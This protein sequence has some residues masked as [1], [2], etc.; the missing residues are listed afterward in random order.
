[1]K[2][3][4]TLV[5]LGLTL[6]TGCAFLH[7]LASTV[8]PTTQPADNGDENPVD[9]A[10]PPIFVSLGSLLG[11]PAV[12]ITA[13][14]LW[15]RFRP[16]KATVEL[17]KAIQRNREIMYQ[18]GSGADNLNLLDAVLSEDVDSGVRATIKRIKK[19]HNIESV[20]DAKD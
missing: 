4:F 2:F 8:A 16:A 11:L 9:E 17:V 6:V 12:G 3:G 19:I 10:M 1:M 20:T 13:A 15:R 5:V 14:A 18:G 7:S